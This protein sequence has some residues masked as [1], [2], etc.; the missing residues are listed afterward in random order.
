[1][2]MIYE[3]Q[4]SELILSTLDKGLYVLE[5]LASLNT[6]EAPTLT[7]LSQHLGMHRSTLL[8]ILATLQF[9][10]YVVRD[11]ATDRYRVGIRVLSISSAVLRNLDIR[12]VARPALQRLCTEMQELVLLT[13][14]SEGMV[15]TIERLEG[16]QTISLRTELGEQRPAYCTA[17]G[18]AILAFMRD[19]EVD[20]IL[21]RGMPAITPRTITSRE[22]MVQQLT[23]INERGFAWDDE[24]RLEGVKCVAAPVFGHEGHVIAAVTVAAFSLRTS[25]ERVWQLGEQTRAAA[26]DISQQLGLQED[27]P[28]GEVG[29][30]GH[31]GLGRENVR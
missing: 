30:S 13:V 27:R 14:L 10:G 8:R 1:M 5:A 19:S 4:E 16:N 17:S 7:E 26:A 2:T 6:S 23:E 24:E 22:A 18:K 9:R 3:K 29:G 15:V 11:R 31:V 28:H 12:Q 21:A 20:R 25:W